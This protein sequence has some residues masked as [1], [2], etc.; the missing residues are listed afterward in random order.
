MSVTGE[1]FLAGGRPARG[2][3][4]WIRSS[5]EC[6]Q[7]EIGSQR[8]WDPVVHDRRFYRRVALGGSLGLG[9]SYMDGWWDCADIGDFFRRL[10]VWRN[11][12]ADD[13]AVRLPTL[14][15]DATFAVLNLQTRARARKVIDVHYDLP[16]SLFECMLGPTMAYSCAYWPDARDLDEAQRCK[17]DLICRKLELAPGERL[18]DLGCGWGS[19]SRHAAEHYG[20]EVVAVTLSSAQAEFVRRHCA[21]LPVAVHVCD[22]R[23]AGRYRGDRRFD[24]IASIAMFEAVGRRNVPGFMR[25][26][27]QLLDERG[28][29]LLHTIGAVRDGTDAWLDRYVFPNGELLGLGGLRRGRGPVPRRGP[30]RVRP[31]LRS[32]ARRMARE[33][34][35]PLGRHPGARP[36]PL[37]RALPTDVG[38]LPRVLPRRLPRP[39]QHPVAAGHGRTAADTGLPGGPAESDPHPAKSRRTD[40]PCEGLQRHAHRS[41]SRRNL[42]SPCRPMSSGS[43][44][45]RTRKLLRSCNA[46]SRHSNAFSRSPRASA[47]M[48]RK[49]GDT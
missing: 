15:L 29:W 42:G 2:A 13:W 45:A 38:L 6:A 33:F 40:G 34:P 11:G 49:Y 27:R 43:S 41:V 25:L 22:Y 23:D 32:D 9:E 21:G 44:P 39:Q 46:C 14:A 37:R 1:G 10:I 26:V 4:R 5:F 28:L 7:I 30:A 3:E 16:A 48:P 18:L 8:A 17:L 24:K 20:C 19:L 31:R 35:A 36:A 12:R 47:A